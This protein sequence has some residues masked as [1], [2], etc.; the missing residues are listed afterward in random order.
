M[1][2]ADRQ[3]VHE[4]LESELTLLG[5]RIRRLSTTLA[6]QVDDRLEAAAY[7]LLSALNDAGDVRAG[8]LAERFGLDKSTVSRQIAQMESMGLVQRVPDPMDGRARLIHTT[9]EGRERV[10]QLREARGRWLRAALED[11][12]ADDVDQMVDLVGRL[13]VA[14]EVREP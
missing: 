3:Q 6:R 12:P 9:D 2:G 1:N 14:L 11:W 5:R 4:Q 7:G 8:D 10:R 13:N